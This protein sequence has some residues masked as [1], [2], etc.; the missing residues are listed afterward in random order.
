MYK[1]FTITSKE[2]NQIENWMFSLNK[3]IRQKIQQ[4]TNMKSEY[5]IDDRINNLNRS[6][7]E[8]ALDVPMIKMTIVASG[9]I[10]K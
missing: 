2:R 5:K 8:L 1:T 4:Q 9:T 7:Q 6:E 3:A 10:E